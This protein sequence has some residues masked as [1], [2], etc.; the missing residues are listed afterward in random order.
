MDF[1]PPNLD[2]VLKSI[3][4]PYYDE[5]AD[6][7]A[8]AEYYADIDLN[9]DPETLFQSVKSLIGK[10]HTE[11]LSFK[12]RKYLHPWVDLRPNLR[13]QSVYSA[14]PVETGA[15]VHVTKRRDFKQ[16][17]RVKVQGRLRADGSRGPRRWKN[18]KTDFRDQAQ[19]WGKVMLEGGAHALDVAQKIAMIEGYKYYNAEHSVPQFVFDRE[20]KGKGDLHHLF[21]CEARANSIRSHFRFGEVPETDEF[22]KGE[23]WVNF[24][25][26]QF[27]PENGKGEVARATL[28]FL[29]RYPGRL[30]DK[31]GEYTKEDVQTLIKWHKE[32]PVGLYELHRNQAIQEIQGNRNPLIDFPELADKIDFNLGLGEWARNQDA[33]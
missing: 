15:K 30:G 11:T 28:Y 4:K 14:E 1:V 8:K 23:G 5:A 20:R 27:E 3:D 29:L 22:R 31:E 17:H 18:R 33:S 21:T 7:K 10:T 2:A 24:E 26:E 32:D 12:P 16:K 6:N 25:T 9:Q 13:L 19:S